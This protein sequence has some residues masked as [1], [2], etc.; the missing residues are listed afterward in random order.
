MKKTFLKSFVGTAIVVAALLSG[1]GGGDREKILIGNW[2]VRD[3]SGSG[4]GLKAFDDPDKLRSNLATLAHS[5]LSLKDD[6]TF[7][8]SGAMTASGTWV[9]DKESGA[10]TLTPASG[11]PIAAS[12]SEGNQQISL[13]N[14]TGTGPAVVLQK[15]D[16]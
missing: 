15:K 10:L 12:L 11:S 1:C 5:D 2:E 9:L 14:P 3:G 6:K 13:P 4:A 16:E 7:A 8:L